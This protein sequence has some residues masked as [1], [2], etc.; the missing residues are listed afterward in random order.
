MVLFVFKMFLEHCFVFGM[1][2][3]AL[4]GVQ[5]KSNIALLESLLFALVYV[6]GP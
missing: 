1:T 5:C 2:A 4:V 3:F 6:V